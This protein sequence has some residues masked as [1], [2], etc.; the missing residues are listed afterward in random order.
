MFIKRDRRRLE[1]IFTDESDER[2]DLNLSK[3]FA[4]FQGSLSPLIRESFVQKLENLATLNLYDNGI[5]D[6]KGIGMLARTPVVDINLGANKLKSL[7]LEFS[8]LKSLRSLWLDDND[9]DSFPSALCALP[10][11]THLHLSNNSLSALPESIAMM[12]GLQVLSVDN[13][14]LG[15]LPKGL[16]D[17]RGLKQLW[18][19]ENEI[20]E[21]PEELGSWVALEILAI[22]SNALT[23]LPA[24][25]TQLHKLQKLYVNSNRISALPEGL[26]AMAALQYVNVSFNSLPLST[27]PESWKQAYEQERAKKNTATAD[28]EMCAQ[29]VVQIAVKEEGSKEMVVVVKGNVFTAMKK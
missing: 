27:L 12:T 9:F 10:S 14:G 4:E 5:S 29:E 20:V 6:I 11:L 22:S 13:N 7:P 21:L 18:A 2:K 28:P 17:I 25:L 23:H 15:G 19:R 3:R 24:S 26:H 16:L 1:E 8:S